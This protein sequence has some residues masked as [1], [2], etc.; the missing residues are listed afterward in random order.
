MYHC[1]FCL[2]STN[3]K[4]KWNKHLKTKKH[5]RLEAEH[6]ETI[7]KE[8]ISSTGIYDLVHEM[9]EQLESMK[10]KDKIRDVEMEEIRKEYANEILNLKKEVS[11]LKELACSPSYVGDNSSNTTV[12]G[13]MNQTNNNIHFHLTLPYGKENWKHLTTEAVMKMMDGVHTCIPELVKK[14][15]FDPEH[16]ENHNVRIV[17]KN[18]PRIE[19]FRGEKWLREPNLNRF[20]DN[21]IKEKVEYVENK[22][23]ETFR[24]N[25]TKF[26]NE[27]WNKKYTS[28][29]NEEKREMKET[30]E[31]VKSEMWNS[32]Q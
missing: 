11:S 30:R 20:V 27:L 7:E 16:P 15:H 17:N 29:I 23:G 31:Q 14:I 5:M 24:N 18:Q 19:T 22:Y 9:K 32:R 6:K 10:I 28:L 25:T 12:N 8:S 4:T 13:T 2:F 26:K 21:L 3:D 1:E